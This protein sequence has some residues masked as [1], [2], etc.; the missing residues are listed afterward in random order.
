MRVLSAQEV[1][2]LWEWGQDR[3]TLDRTLGFLAV[4][5]PDA[6]WDELAGL[7]IGQRDARILA[8][9]EFTVGPR[10][11]GFA[12]CKHRLLPR[13]EARV[14]DD[15]ALSERESERSA[16]YVG[17][18]ST[19]TATSGST[20][21]STEVRAAGSWRVLRTANGYRTLHLSHLACEL[22]RHIGQY[23]QRQP[24]GYIFTTDSDKRRS[25][26]AT[27]GPGS[28]TRPSKRRNP[29]HPHDLRHVIVCKLAG[30]GYSDAQIAYWIGDDA[31]TA[32]RTY[33]N[34]LVNTNERIGRS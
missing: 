9:R 16:A 26:Q 15:V 23:A 22:Q 31:R 6:S 25:A 27:G 33:R 32:A 13:T 18:G 10:L 3:H 17:I 2:S 20:A 8:L 34:V 12:E 28:S 4:A 24:D 21:S 11:Q 14:L 29:G 1:L 30:Q 5:Y 7:S 19:S